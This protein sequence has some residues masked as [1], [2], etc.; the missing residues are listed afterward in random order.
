MN[1]H[2]LE[3][4]GTIRRTPMSMS[5][6]LTK[7][8]GFTFLPGQWAQFTL[9]VDGARQSKPLSISSSP[10]EP[11]LEF[12]KRITGSA[13][14]Q[15]IAKLKLRDRVFLKG[16]AGNLVYSGGLETVTFIA[17]GI[18][19]TPVRSILKYLMDRKVGGKKVFLY[20]NLSVEETAFREEIREWEVKDPGLTV[21]H[22]L[23][24]PPE[25]WKGHTGFINREIIEKSVPQLSNQIFYVSGPPPM[26]K[27]V[28][29]A[30]DQLG[31][32]MEKR[33]TEKLEGY[34][35]MV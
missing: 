20:G 18:G 24:K 2:T 29:G 4:T 3:V 27:A 17:G 6:R 11:F 5:V 13:F 14:S 26:V 34:E 9:S 15:A 32:P 23:E 22:V 1:E 35:G 12:T 10:T 16:P 25:G 28:S 31:I 19:I 21:I 8:A 33:V 7:P 30:L